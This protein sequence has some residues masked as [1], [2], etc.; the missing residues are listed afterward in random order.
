MVQVNMESG[1][2]MVHCGHRLITLPELRAI[3]PPPP[4]GPMHR[5]I[6]HS[7]LIDGVREALDRYNVTIED[8]SLSVGGRREEH[9]DV[10]ITG[11]L[12]LSVP[13]VEDI[14]MRVGLGLKADNVCET[15]V[16]LIG[17]RNVFSCD[18]WALIGDAIVMRE[19]H[20]RSLNL[21]QT[22][23]SAIGIFLDRQG[24]IDETILR[25]KQRFLTDN[26][27]KVFLYDL[28]CKSTLPR[29]LMGP[30]H[31]CYF[32]TAIHQPDVVPEV[33]QYHGT[34]WGLHNAVTRQLKGLPQHRLMRHTQA[35]D[36]PF[37]RLSEHVG[38]S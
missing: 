15:A 13:S 34:A 5:P 30:V 28:F 29:R 38:L 3:E 10:A 9:R 12:Q 36:V 2:H 1:T 24:T 14:E 7:D 27:A 26:R 6:K 17:G 20:L 37:R 4:L 31:D 18:N 16:H 25:M 35:I 8:M 11:L 32:T 19:R 33:A 22:L 21:Q 23:A